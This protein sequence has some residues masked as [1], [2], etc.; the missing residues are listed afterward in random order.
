MIF[1]RTG[2]LICLTAAVIPEAFSGCNGNISKI[3][4]PLLGTIV[5]ITINDYPENTAGDF[6]AAFKE[7]EAVQK[8]FSLYDPGSDIS[9]INKS[10]FPRPYKVNREVF[11]LIKRSL[12]V[13][14]KTDG[15]FDITFAS[16]GKLW[17]FSQENFTPPDDAVIK[18][19]LPLISYRN[20]KLNSTGMTIQFLKAGTKIGLGGVAKGY[21]TGRAIDALKKRGV[22]NAIVASAGDIQVI[23]DNNG[24]PWM[25]GIQDP[26]GKDVIGALE[27][28]NGEAVSTS[29][30]YERFRIVNG[31]R[32]HHII[33]PATGYPA[34]SGLISVSVFSS[35]PVLSDVYSTAFFVSGLEKTQRILAEMNDLSAVLVTEDMTVHV[36]IKLK[37]RIIFRE[38]LKVVYF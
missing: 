21:A 31:R 18:K 24:K 1:N 3:S 35:D 8:E 29:G 9:Q 36:S 11:N 33:N 26:R 15:A 16:T 37:G 14:E 28:N 34:D 27:M 2:F 5:T 19:L 10:A 6:D 32:Y 38:D 30:D 23:G 22:K 4:R 20:I 12:E 13:S 7:I 17:D 25:T